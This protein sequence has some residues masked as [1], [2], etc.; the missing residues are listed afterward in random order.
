MGPED[1]DCSICLQKFVHPAQ[2]PCGHIFCFLCIKGCAFHRRRCPICRQQFSIRFF[3]DPK[4]LLLDATRDGNSTVAPNISSTASSTAIPCPEPTATSS[5]PPAIA[6]DLSPTGY[7]WFYEGFAGWWEYDE[8]T[9]ADLEDAFS[10]GYTTCEIVVAGHIYVIDFCAMSQRRKDHTG[11][12]R[13]IKRDFITCEKKGI[14][15][16]KLAAI[17]PTTTSTTDTTTLTS[18]TFGVAAS[19]NTNATRLTTQSS[20]PAALVDHTY[21]CRTPSV[22]ISVHNT[23]H[24]AISCSS[25]PT[26]QRVPNSQVSLSLLPIVSPAV[27]VARTSSRRRSRPSRRS[28]PLA[29]VS[30]SLDSNASSLLTLSHLP[31]LL[32]SDPVVGVPSTNACTSASPNHRYSTRSLSHH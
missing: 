20:Q 2:L 32:P 12:K 10:N 14:A 27:D 8:R 6:D 1:T 18:T 30:D 16:I 19:L 24:R 21:A 26:S 25:S 28:P 13:R 5:L 7:S 9:S 4:L 11:R 3:D 22:S 17:Q 15:G 31:A 23:R 29:L